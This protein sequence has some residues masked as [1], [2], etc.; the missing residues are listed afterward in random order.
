MHSLQAQRL[1]RSRVFP[2]PGCGCGGRASGAR[3]WTS[4]VHPVS[5]LIESVQEHRQ[6]GL[7]RVSLRLG[8][9][10]SSG[11]SLERGRAR[12]AALAELFERWAAHQPCTQDRIWVSRLGA[13]GRR[14]CWS[15]LV[16][17]GSV[18]R[19][20]GQ[21]LSHGLACGSTLGRA[22]RSGFWEL[23]ERDALRRWWGDWRR[24]RATQLCRL[25]DDL[26]VLPG[27]VY[28][29]FQGKQGRGAWGT[30]AGPG[31]AEKARLEAL[32]NFQVLERRPPA[33]PSECLSF[34]DH[35][36]WGWHEPILRWD[37]MTSMGVLADPPVCPDWR[38]LAGSEK[39]YYLELGCD[40]AEQQG[41][42]VVKVLS[43][44]WRGLSIGGRPPF[45]PFS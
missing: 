38:Q 5:G 2:Y 4:W 37:E 20:H 27:P 35:A 31:G 12:R 43:P 21:Q 40:W 34:A 15:G 11:A 23:F 32:H 36:A 8:P 45:H 25:A 42:K 30:A 44:V 19:P 13:R 14:R 24:G 18:P 29:A 41:W 39:V 16:Y 33:R 7:W 22:L 3:D 10:A 6:D 17:L 1:F 26:W 28:L 9:A